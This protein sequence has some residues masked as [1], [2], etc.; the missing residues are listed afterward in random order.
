MQSSKRNIVIIL[1]YYL[2]HHIAI[3]I[4]PFRFAFSHLPR[5][6]QLFQQ[7]HRNNLTSNFCANF[8]RF[9]DSSKPSQSESLIYEFAW[10]AGFRKSD[11]NLIKTSCKDVP[12]IKVAHIFW[13]RHD[14]RKQWASA[15]EHWCDV[16][17]RY[18]NI[19]RDFYSDVYTI[20]NRI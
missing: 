12:V 1:A 10:L 20:L 17:A 14:N 5:C 15:R 16:N 7:K 11:E 8:L 18:A 3:T 9:S 2:I 6:G 4:C 13:W 19:K